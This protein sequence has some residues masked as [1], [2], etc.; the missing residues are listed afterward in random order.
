MSHETSTLAI[1]TVSPLMSL[2]NARLAL[3]G[4]QDKLLQQLFALM[5]TAVVRRMLGH[6]TK[7]LGIVFRMAD[8]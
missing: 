8:D 7:V 6:Q 1:V 2:H 4:V 3:A 5:L